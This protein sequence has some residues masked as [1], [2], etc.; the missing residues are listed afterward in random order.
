[1]TDAFDI[2]P[3][4]AAPAPWRAVAASVVCAALVVLS[5]IDV[6]RRI[7][8]PGFVGALCALWAVLGI[9]CAMRSGA[10]FAWHWACAGLAGAVAGAGCALA[11]SFACK[12]SSADEP[13]GMGDVKLLFAL[14]LYGGPAFVLACLGA[15]CLL[16]LVYAAARAAFDATRRRVTPCRAF[17]SFDGTFAFVPF[18]SVAFCALML[19]A[20]R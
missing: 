20:M 10:V 5:A 15:A 7:V 3:L 19:F 18:L 12:S 2:V 17:D 13:L 4:L 8:A 1:M 14:G 6:R 11:C 9:A 16:A